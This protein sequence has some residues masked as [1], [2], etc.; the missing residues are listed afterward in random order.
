MKT[1]SI[2]MSYDLG[3]GGDYQT[4][5]QWLDD[6]GAVECGNSVA[7]LK[8]DYPNSIKSD[9]ELTKSIADELKLKIK[10]NPSN[11]VYIIRKRLNENQFY[12]SYIIGKRRANPWQGYGSQ[13]DKTIDE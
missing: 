11:R 13:A 9:D 3:V 10:F 1:I 8:Y 7:F 4:L 2:W 6:H 12:G 5:Y